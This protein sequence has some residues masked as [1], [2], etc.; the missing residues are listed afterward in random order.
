MKEVVDDGDYFELKRS[1]KFDS[2]PACW[3]NF[4]E[5]QSGEVTTLL[6]SFYDKSRGDRNKEP[7]SIPNLEKY[8]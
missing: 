6:G 5:P 3:K 7:W 4:E 8:I 1:M 2:M